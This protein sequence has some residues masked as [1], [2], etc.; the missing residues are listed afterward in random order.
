MRYKNYHAWQTG[1]QGKA[2]IYREKCL[3]LLQYFKQ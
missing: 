1:D 2:A 3:Q